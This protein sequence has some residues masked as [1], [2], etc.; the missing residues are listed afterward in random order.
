MA[1]AFPYLR[2]SKAL[3]HAKIFN[4]RS[5]CSIYGTPSGTYDY[6]KS[7][8][9]KDDKL[10]HLVEIEYK[11]MIEEWEEDITRTV[12]E[13]LGTMNTAFKNHPFGS[14][15]DTE[16]GRKNWGY[17]VDFTSKAIKNIGELGLGAKV[18]SEED[19]ED[20]QAE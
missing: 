14:V 20:E 17:N 5:A 8:L 12:K 4:K 3:A 10:F 19:E 18:L 9:K 6:W 7:R 16:L 13:A 15:P 1:I 11:R 2:A